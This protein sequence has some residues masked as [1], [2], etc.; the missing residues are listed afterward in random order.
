MKNIL[1]YS[2]LSLLLINTLAG[3]L[4]TKYMLPN[5]LVANFTIIY[6]F[7]LNYFVIKNKL[8]E[9]FKVSLS[10]ILP[11]IWLISF[12][13]AIFMDSSYKDNWALLILVLFQILQLLIVIITLKISKSKKYSI[14]N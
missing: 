14:C 1:F 9:A 7:S 12:I 11:S 4:L 13:I 8:R 10:F 6:S 2:Y 5:I 3:V